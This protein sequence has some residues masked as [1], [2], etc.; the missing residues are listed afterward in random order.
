[1]KVRRTALNRIGPETI[2][3]DLPMA[4]IEEPLVPIFMY[5]RYAVEAAASMLAGQN[6][7]YAIR[8]DNRTPYT[9]ETAANQ[10]KALEAI[11]ATLKPSTHY[12][13]EDSRR[14]SSTPAG[15][16]TPSRPFP[17]HHRRCVRRTRAWDHSSRCLDWLSA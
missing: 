13:Q 6:Y 10:R 14:Y 12:P 7:V 16:R 17:P 5:A 15:L 3:R 9:W 1:M 4:M 11:A 8:G 2:R